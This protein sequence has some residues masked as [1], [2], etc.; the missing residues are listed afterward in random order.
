[1]D[2]QTYVAYIGR[3]QRAETVRELHAIATEVRAAH[4]TDPDAGKIADLC[5]MYAI[6]RLQHMHRTGRAAAR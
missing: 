4:P 2:Q 3:A 5:Q 6:D 1:M